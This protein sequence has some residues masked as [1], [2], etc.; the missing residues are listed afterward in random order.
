MTRQRQLA[1]SLGPAAAA[2][3]VALVVSALVLVATGS[4][5]FETFSVMLDHGTK[6]E[7]IIASVNRAVP[8]F[9][10]AVAAS[11]G[12]RMNLFNIGVEGQYL[13]ASFAAAAIAAEYTLP[14]PLH[15]GSIILIAMVV[16]ALAAGVAGLLKVTRGVNEVI[17]TI[18]LN[19]I[20]IGGIIAALFP[21]VLDRGS[22]SANAG[23]KVLA[24]S[25]WLPGLNGA[26]ETFTREIRGATELSSMIIVAIIVGVVYDVVVN[27]ARIGFDLRASGMNPFA[28]RAG[29]VPPKRML[30]FAMLASGAIAGLIGM[31]EVL[32]NQHSYDQSFIQGLGFAGIAVALMGRLNAVGMAVAALIFGFIDS[33]AAILQVRDLASSSITRIIQATVLF[34]AVIAYQVAERIRQQEE[35]RA[36]GEAVSRLDDTLDMEDSHV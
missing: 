22:N 32:S 27:R 8:L 26:V 28:A 15:I 25:A 18:M 24:E 2:A 33:S 20:Y 9:L 10:S 13:L 35:I 7:Q 5:P 36:A 3:V 12:F 11:I 29:G 31:P 1:L 16:G 34:A 23:T 21:R 17:S 30:L 6:L 4:N 14:A 19:S